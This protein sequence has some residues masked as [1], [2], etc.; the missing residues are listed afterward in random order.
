MITGVGKSTDPLS[1]RVLIICAGQGTR[2]EGYLGTEKHLV[3]I[4]GE[5]LLDRTVRLLSEQGVGNVCVVTKEYD[6]RYNVLGT[7]QEVVCVDYENNVD[8]DKFLSSKHLWHK[9]GRTI[10]LYGDCYFTD[11]AMEVIV[12]FPKREWTLFC[13]PGASKLTG[14]NWGECFAQSFYP[15][16]LSEHEKKLRQDRKSVV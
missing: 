13:R 14:T 3:E 10:V 16:H 8:A 12:H 15:E 9:A 4:E 2:W 7:S 1:V 5:R 11:Q 6:E